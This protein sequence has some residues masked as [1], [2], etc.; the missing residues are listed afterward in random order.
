MHVEATQVVQHGQRDRRQQIISCLEAEVNLDR[1]IAKHHSNAASSIRLSRESG[2][3]AC[4]R[5]AG[6]VRLSTILEYPVQ[7]W[8]RI[9][10]LLPFQYYKIEE[11]RLVRLYNPKPCSC[12]DLRFHLQSLLPL[13]PPHIPHTHTHRHAYN[14][15]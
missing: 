6:G 12:T 9:C 11:D 8:G 3:V 13:E 2:M 10:A 4:E 5:I 7:H 15:S 14:L 1:M